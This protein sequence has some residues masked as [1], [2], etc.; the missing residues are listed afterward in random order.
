MKKLWIIIIFIIV[1]M[2]GYYWG[3]GIDAPLASRKALIAPEDQKPLILP[4]RIKTADCIVE[5]SLPDPKCTPGAVFPAA[6]IEQVC[7]YG[8]TKTVRKV[9]VSLK[10]QVYREYGLKYPPIFGSYEA[11]HF[12]PLALGGTNDIANLWPEAAGPPPGFREKDLV[13]NYLHD[14]VCAGQ[15]SL[16]AAQ[17]AISANWITVYNG[18]SPAEIANLKKQY[19]SWTPN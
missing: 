3:Q 17:R 5:N 16:S 10:K 2:T 13:E 19:R 14:Q 8:Y 4:P 11:D 12:I 15:M 6:T 18:L 1:G 7:A 9:S